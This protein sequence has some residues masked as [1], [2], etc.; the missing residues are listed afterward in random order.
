MLAPAIVWLAS[1]V[2]I[3]AD[4]Q[5]PEG[6]RAWRFGPVFLNGTA[7]PTVITVAIRPPEK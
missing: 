1:S 4:S 3:A 5:A 7:T 6:G 2:S